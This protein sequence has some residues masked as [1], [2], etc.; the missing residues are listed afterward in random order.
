MKQL[1]RE[2]K[3]RCW[4]VSRQDQPTLCRR[5]GAAVDKLKAFITTSGSVPGDKARVAG[6]IE[7]MQKKPQAISETPHS[8]G[9]N[10]LGLWT[11]VDIR[12]LRCSANRQPSNPSGN[13]G[14]F[15]PPAAA[16]T[17]FIPRLHASSPSCMPLC[18]EFAFEIYRLLLT[19]L[20]S[21]PHFNQRCPSN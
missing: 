5:G 2:R 8:P 10:R 13:T 18:L 17:T 9:S 19:V 12:F 3:C 21:P 1:G 15:G 16:R 7:A 20:T 11:C 14:A 6:T 4:I